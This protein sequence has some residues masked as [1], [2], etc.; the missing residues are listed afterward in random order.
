MKKT[1]EVNRILTKLP[2]IQTSTL[3]PYYGLEDVN[4]ESIWSYRREFASLKPNHSWNALDIKDFLHRIGAWGW[5]RELKEEGLTLAGL[6]MFGELKAITE[7][8]PNYFLSYAE[9]DYLSPNQ[10]SRV[11]ITSADGTWSGNVYDFFMKV[12]ARVVSNLDAST[13]FEG[14]DTSVVYRAIREKI[15]NKLVDGDYN[16]DNVFLITKDKLQFLFENLQ[17]SP[18]SELSFRKGLSDSRNDN[19]YKIFRAIAPLSREKIFPFPNFL[20]TYNIKEG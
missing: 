19:I 13:Q 6:V 5:N 16:R 14:T 7:V 2:D 17:T 18:M 10:K 1:N 8:L 9:K 3:L 20:N 4:I 15:V 12:N 11:S